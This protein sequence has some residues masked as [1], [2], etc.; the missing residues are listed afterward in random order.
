MD[1]V[2]INVI[3]TAINFDIIWVMTEGG[4]NY[5]TETLPIKIYRY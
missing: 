5:A 1:I 2:Y 4:P 3:K